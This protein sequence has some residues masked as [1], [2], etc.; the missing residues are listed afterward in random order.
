[1]L[2]HFM[3]LLRWSYPSRRGTVWPR[4]GSVSTA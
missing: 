3:P 1:M 4:G 2:G